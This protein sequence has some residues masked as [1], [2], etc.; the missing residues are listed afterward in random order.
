MWDQQS[1]DVRTPVDSVP[2]LSL[3]ETNPDLTTEMLQDIPQ[4]WSEFDTGPVTSY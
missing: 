4:G 3:L 1:I 2:E